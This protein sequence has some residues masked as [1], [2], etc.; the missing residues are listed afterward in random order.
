MTMLHKQIF[1]VQI[2]T[3]RFKK[4]LPLSSHGGKGKY[5]WEKVLHLFFLATPLSPVKVVC[6][7]KGSLAD[8]KQER[9]ISHTKSRGCSLILGSQAMGG[10][11]ECR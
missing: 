1:V 5:F 4:N 6:V 2:G 10:R 9:I 11:G 3:H 7:P 8:S